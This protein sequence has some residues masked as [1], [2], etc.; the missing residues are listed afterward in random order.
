[1]QMAHFLRRL[2]K[3]LITL[4]TVTYLKPRYAYKNFKRPYTH[5]FQKRR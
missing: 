2:L 5:L 4:Y 3:S 1:M